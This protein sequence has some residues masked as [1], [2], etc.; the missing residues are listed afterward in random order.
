[1][2]FDSNLDHVYYIRNRS[3]NIIKIFVSYEWCTKYDMVI[4]M[5]KTLSKVET[6][7]EIIT[8]SLVNL[9]KPIQLLM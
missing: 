2:Y 3:G 4:T 6:N 7:F 9:W 1:M 5:G 8:L